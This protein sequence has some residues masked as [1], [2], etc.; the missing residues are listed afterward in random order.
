MGFIHVYVHICPYIYLCIHIV[1]G[2]IYPIAYCL[3]SIRDYL[4]FPRCCSLSILCSEIL[5]KINNHFEMY[6]W[7]SA[8][9]VA[10]AYI[11]IYGIVN[12]LNWERIYIILMAVGIMCGWDF[13]I[14]RI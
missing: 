7:V 13:R 8:A 10:A 3:R 2:I 11:Y 5:C 6:V 1:Q 12:G 4:Y 14:I 9:A